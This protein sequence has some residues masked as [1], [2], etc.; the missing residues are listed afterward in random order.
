[1]TEPAEIVGERT[2]FGT[3]LNKVFIPSH[4]VDVSCSKMA[5]QETEMRVRVFCPGVGNGV[6]RK[7]RMIMSQ[8]ALCRK[9]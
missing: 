3:M 7:V 8:L 1:M 9:Q 2:P 4:L 5:P 6:V